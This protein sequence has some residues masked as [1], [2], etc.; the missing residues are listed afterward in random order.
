MMRH[1]GKSDLAFMGVAEHIDADAVSHKDNI[2]ARLGLD[3]RGGRVIGGYDDDLLAA[4]L[5]I[6]IM[7]SLSH[8]AGLLTGL[9]RNW[10]IGFGS[11]RFAVG[12]GLGLAG[13]LDLLPAARAFVAAGQ[14][15][16]DSEK[17][18]DNPDFAF[19]VEP[20][21]ARPEQALQLAE[22]PSCSKFK[23]LSD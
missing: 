18:R 8:D 13:I 6:E 14:E 11:A 4:P 2:D 5:H 22:S 15:R 20:F 3:P 21:T 17:Q 19:H 12:A 16:A 9:G 7:R 1:I 10:R 23:S